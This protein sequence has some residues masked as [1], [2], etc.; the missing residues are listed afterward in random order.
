MSH[1]FSNS[2]LA[3]QLD[4]GRIS[5]RESGA[6]FADIARVL[7]QLSDRNPSTLAS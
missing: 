3:A 2:S 4:F 1:G 7:G 6:K 5:S